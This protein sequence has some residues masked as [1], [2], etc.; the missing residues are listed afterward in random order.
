MTS[1]QQQQQ[2]ISPFSVENIISKK[3]DKDSDETLNHSSS[4]SNSYGKCWPRKVYNCSCRME[5]SPSPRVNFVRDD[6]DDVIRSKESIDLITLILTIPSHNDV[7]NIFTSDKPIQS[8]F[9]SVIRVC[10]VQLC[11]K[12]SKHH[13]AR[14]RQANNQIKPDHPSNRGK[15]RAIV[16]T[17]LRLHGESSRTKST[18]INIYFSDQLAT[19]EKE[20]YK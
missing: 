10:F 7:V 2:F 15:T 13:H 12:W 18:M 8:D 11:P 1:M 19:L 17:E 20:F 4:S 6:S 5:C 9:L 3:A 16:G 14:H